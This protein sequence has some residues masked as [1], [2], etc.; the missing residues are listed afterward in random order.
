MNLLDCAPPIAGV[1]M[2]AWEASAAVLS[3]RLGSMLVLVLSISSGLVSGGG[4][5]HVRADYK[6]RG[7]GGP[8][9]S[10]GTVWLLDKV[11]RADA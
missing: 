1:C 9:D 2:P 8:M 5:S 7:G 11:T 3:S 4:V 6:T 10:F